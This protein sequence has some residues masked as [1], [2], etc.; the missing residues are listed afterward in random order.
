MGGETHL[1]FNPVS[2]NYFCGFGIKYSTFESSVSALIYQKYQI[3][4]L[5]KDEGHIWALCGIAVGSLL[6]F[7]W[8]YNFPCLK[9]ELYS[10]VTPYTYLKALCTGIC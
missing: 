2:K 10:I 7:T 4:P 6:S 1:F 5:V 3:L 8:S 9:L